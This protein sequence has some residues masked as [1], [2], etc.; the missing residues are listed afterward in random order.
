MRKFGG[1][2]F[3]VNADGLLKP[4]D[5]E[6]ERFLSYLP[7]SYEIRLN[8][9]EDSEGNIQLS[10]S[11]CPASTANF[12]TWMHVHNLGLESLRE[13]SNIPEHLIRAM[14][15][16]QKEHYEEM[17]F[18]LRFYVE[19]LRQLK[20]LGKGS[21]SDSTLSF[22]EISFHAREMVCDLLSEE[23]PELADLVTALLSIDK[24]YA[25]VAENPASLKRDDAFRMRALWPEVSERKIAQVLEVSNSTVSGWFRGEEGAKKL[26]EVRN[27]P[28]MIAQFLAFS[29]DSSNKDIAQHFQISTE[30]VQELLNRPDFKKMVFALRR[31]AKASRQ[32]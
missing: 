9:S 6:A 29:P 25:K 32:L 24:T 10:F 15:V 13:K 5:E 30:K 1:F 23:Y 28:S 26:E 8:A 18:L 12:D 11:D 2:S 17:A 3:V 22:A 16:F 7:D 31:S 14:D 27:S 20:E 21:R 19:H 4:A